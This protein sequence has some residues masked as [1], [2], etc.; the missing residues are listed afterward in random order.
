MIARYTRPAMGKIWDD[1]N[2]F[3][4]WL[5][6]E[7]LACEAQAELGTIPKEAARILREKASFNVAR[8]EEI[9]QE[10]K[11]DVIAFLTNVGEYTGPESRFMHVGMTSSDVL[12]TCLAVQ[13]KQ[14]GE[15]LL[16]NLAALEGVLARRARGERNTEE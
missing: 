6:I 16:D 13:M 14:S 7:L 5:E 12:D 9:E 3:R 11:H 2:K 8:I 15:I 4:V 1:E 10:V